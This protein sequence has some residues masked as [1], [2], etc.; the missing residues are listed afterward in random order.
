MKKINRLQYVIAIIIFITLTSYN[1][2]PIVLAEDYLVL[3]EVYTLN[4]IQGTTLMPY[5]APPQVE[6]VQTMKVTVTAYSST[7]AQTDS[8]PFI[9]ASNKMVR[10]GIVANN[11]LAFGTN[12]KLPELFGNKIFQ[13]EDRMAKRK[14]NYHVDIWFESTK[15]AIEFGIKTATLEILDK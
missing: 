14:G 8:T 10:D 15:D 6:V 9:T 7:V 5:V 4:I 2:R 1:I 11:L 3:R 12:V 13:V